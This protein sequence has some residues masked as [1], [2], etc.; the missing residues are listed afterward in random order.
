MF[1]NII[2][3][4][5]VKTFKIRDVFQVC[6]EFGKTSTILFSLEVVPHQCFKTFSMREYFSAYGI[7]AFRA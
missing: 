1:V 4:S 5:I 2:H 7:V 6:T 3:N